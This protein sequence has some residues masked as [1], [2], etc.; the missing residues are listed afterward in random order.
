MAGTEETH[1]FQF[2][3][4]C[5]DSKRKPLQTVLYRC[6]IDRSTGLRECRYVITEAYRSVGVLSSLIA[7]RVSWIT[8]NLRAI[9]SHFPTW[10]LGV[11]DTAP[12]AV[13]FTMASPPE[14][15]PTP[16][17]TLRSDDHVRPTV[18]MKEEVGIEQEA[19]TAP[20]TVT[21]GS[22]Q[23]TSTGGSAAGLQS[24]KTV[25][26]DTSTNTPQRPN[27]FLEEDDKQV[28]RPPYRDSIASYRGVSHTPVGLPSTIPHANIRSAETWPPS[29]TLRVSQV[30]HL[31]TQ[32]L[33]ATPAVTMTSLLCTD[34]LGDISYSFTP[35]SATTFHTQQGATVAITRPQSNGCGFDNPPGSREIMNYFNFVFTPG[36]PSAQLPG[37]TQP[38]MYHVAA[39]TA[40]SMPRR[41]SSPLQPFV[42]KKSIE[43]IA[44][45]TKRKVLKSTS[46]NAANRSSA[47]GKPKPVDV[48]A[49]L[50]FD[51]SDRACNCPKSR[52]IKLYCECFHRGLVCDVDKC[53]CKR[54][55]NTTEESGP[56]GKRTAAALKILSKRPNGFVVRP[57][58][59]GK[60]CSCKKNR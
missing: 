1:L 46:A 2:S 41:V 5:N 19:P 34:S 6:E 42:P 17:P 3:R 14:A 58:K 21:S 16:K 9:S 28:G 38:D 33:I 51:V 22:T 12:F 47:V 31:M 20:N 53:T 32:P 10:A 26:K 4:E 59:R 50:T 39:P 43:A 7:A 48:F 24:N 30:G 8:S 37:S 18:A 57:K 60:G 35:A 23:T 13:F 25:A 27:F 29:L 52:C 49:A 55:L 40:A 36:P 15:A 11:V 54:C 44:K 56:K 45:A